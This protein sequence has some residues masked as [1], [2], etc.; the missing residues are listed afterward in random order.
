M[1]R[2]KPINL[3]DTRQQLEQKLVEINEEF[4]SSTTL[5]LISHILNKPK[6]WVLAHGEYEPTAQ[7]S[8]SLQALI[9]RFSQGTPLPYLLGQWEFFG[10][11]FKISPDVLIPRP[12]TELLVET[13]LQNLARWSKPRIVDVGTG[14]GIIAISLASACPSANI[15][16]LDISWPALKVAQQNARLHNQ[17]D[18]QFIQA[19]LL[20]ALQTKFDMICANL[21]YIP[22]KILKKLLV[23]RWE[24]QLALDGG[25]DGMKYIR[26]LLQ[27]AKTRLALPGVLLLEIEASQGQACLAAC[28]QQFPNANSRLHQDLGGHDRL[29]EIQAG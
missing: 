22:S 7:E 10:R 11:T 25:G 20:N 12:E 17:I 3:L 8:D 2:S 13:A 26:Q 6:S 29:I 28:Q 21:P 23:S 14:S 27:Q 15:T 16:A 4:P 19:N 24:P 18:I 5:L 9:V 1:L